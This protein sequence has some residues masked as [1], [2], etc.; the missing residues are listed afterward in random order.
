M[1][2]QPIGLDAGQLKPSDRGG[3]LGEGDRRRSEQSEQRGS[4]HQALAVGHVGDVA[5]GEPGPV[6]LASH[7][8][9][10]VVVEVEGEVGQP[11]R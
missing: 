6:L 2:L 5:Q 10:G 1:E 3:D 4:E 9:E 11:L 8:L 7:Q